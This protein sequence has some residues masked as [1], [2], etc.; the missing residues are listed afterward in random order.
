MGS[1]PAAPATSEPPDYAPAP[2]N[3]DTA[4]INGDLYFDLRGV[5]APTTAWICR[6]L[7]TLEPATFKPTI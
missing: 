5:C 7:A 6:I 3:M 1:Q 2:I 4:D